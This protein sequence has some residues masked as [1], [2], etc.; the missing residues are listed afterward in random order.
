MM[1]LY[2]NALKDLE[3][4]YQNMR[5]NITINYTQLGLAFT[6]HSAEVLFNI[7]LTKIY[8]GQTAPGMI[9]LRKAQEEKMMP[10][11][12]FIDDA[13]RDRGRGCNVFT[14]PVSQSPGLA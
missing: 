14:V 4:A 2:E 12:S 13:V 6:I 3:R 10:E 7:G 8:L 5:D 1:A 9:D 11:H